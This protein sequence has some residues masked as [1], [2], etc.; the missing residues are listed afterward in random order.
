MAQINKALYNDIIDAYASIDT[1][2]SGIQANARIA[3]DAVVDVTTGNYPDPSANADAALQVELA[4]LQVFNSAYVAS[5]NI[6]N[7]TASLL[8]AVTTVN[9]FVITETP[10]TATATAKLLDWINVEML[11][12]YTGTNCPLGWA[13]M[14]ADAGYTTTGCTTE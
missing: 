1:S 10:G 12:N 3:L 9:D 11:G 6:A 7:S 14:S 5:A 13:N 2:L 8:D 4:L